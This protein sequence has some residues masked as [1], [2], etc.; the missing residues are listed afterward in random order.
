MD[1]RALAGTLL[2]AL[3]ESDLD[4]VAAACRENVVVFGTDADEIWHDRA[5]LL[6]GIEPFVGAGMS[7]RWEGDPDCG[8]N[9]VAGT[10]IYTLPDGSTVPVRVSMVFD[11]D[12]LAHGHFS[13]AVPE[14]LVKE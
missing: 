9:W 6:A 4:R 10:A 12:R 14:N 2:D 3:A 13:V 7:A 8:S 1:L 5:G 11:G